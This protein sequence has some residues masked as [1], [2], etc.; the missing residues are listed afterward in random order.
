MALSHD[1]GWRYEIMTTNMSE[2]FNGVLKSARN[3]PITTLVQLTFYWINTYFT[4]KWEHGVGRLAS[5]EEFTPYINAKIKAKVV[6]VGSHEVV[7][8]DHV[9]GH[10][11][12]KTR[13]SIGSSNR[14]PTHIMLTF[15][16]G[17][18]TCNKT[19][20]L[21]FPC[22]HIL[23]VCH[24]R[25]IDFRQFV[26]GYYTTCAYL[27]TW[28]SLFYPIFDELEWPQYNG[29]IIVPFDSMKR[30]TSG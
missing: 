15:K 21:G 25:A 29:P 4:V 6:K 7:L 2:V 3:L 22:S 27:S 26:Q 5:S 9:E 17:S 18:C 11:H 16:K 24:C 30:L 12:V 23:A 28:A 8:Y 10:F 20:L 1:D 14:N 19:F 13:H